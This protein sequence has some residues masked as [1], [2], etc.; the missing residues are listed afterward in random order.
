MKKLLFILLYLPM[1]GFG[2][3]N[4]DD[5][6]LKG[7]KLRLDGK[8][9]FAIDQFTKA[10]DLNLKNGEAYENRA[11]CYFVKGKDES[12]IKDYSKAISLGY[13]NHGIIFYDRGLV[14]QWKAGSNSELAEKDY[15]QAIELLLKKVDFNKDDYFLGYLKL[16][17]KAK[18]V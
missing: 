5:Y 14:Y 1:V 8:Y 18:Q 7:L 15:A 13:F 4:S 11:G 6:L 3:E 9:T 17:W 10:I 16:A 12:A 2:Q